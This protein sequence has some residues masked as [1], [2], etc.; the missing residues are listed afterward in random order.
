MSLLWWSLSWPSMS[1]AA[2]AVS[3]WSMSED[4]TDAGETADATD[5]IDDGKG[6]IWSSVA[7]IELVE[8]LLLG[9]PT[10]AY[11]RLPSWPCRFIDRPVKSSS[12]NESSPGHVLQHLPGSSTGSSQSGLGQSCFMF[13]HF[14]RVEVRWFF[15]F[16]ST[17]SQRTQKRVPRGAPK[18]GFHLSFTSYVWLPKMQVFTCWTGVNL[19]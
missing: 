7:L 17:H 8:V 2:T 16:T 18:L 9:L 13:L 14:T 6:D 15:R 4:E 5:V 11:I 10:M 19:L 12:K 3:F 1:V